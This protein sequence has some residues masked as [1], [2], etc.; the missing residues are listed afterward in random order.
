MYSLPCVMHTIPLPSSID[1]ELIYLL[2]NDYL[3]S[4]GT[5]L[6][7]IYITNAILKA[8]LYP[9]SKQVMLPKF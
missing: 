3:T 6:H 7:E 8:V 9:I 5:S 4:S 1:S 2:M